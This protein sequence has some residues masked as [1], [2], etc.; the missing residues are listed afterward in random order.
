MQKQKST[1]AL[2][3]HRNPKLLQGHVDDIIG[4][5]CVAH[6]QRLGLQRDV[7][8][9]QLAVCYIKY[10]KQTRRRRSCHVHVVLTEL[11]TKRA[12][13]QPHICA[14]SDILGED[15]QGDGLG[16]V[17]VFSLEDPTEVKERCRS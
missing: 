11:K 7:T 17:P 10:P 16:V 13:K 8:E 12:K 5:V 14:V 4:A 1:V 9:A 6:R 15:F 2:V 3:S